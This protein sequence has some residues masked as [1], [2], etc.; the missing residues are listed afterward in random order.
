MG[1][2]NLGLGPALVSL[3]CVRRQSTAAR[4]LE[5]PAIARHHASPPGF[6]RFPIPK[7]T[8]LAQVLAAFEGCLRDHAA[9]LERRRGSGMIFLVILTY[10]YIYIHNI[11]IYIFIIIYIYTR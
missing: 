5:K 1:I 4:H 9:V 11:Y 3:E 6:C 7:R 8:R 2:F 10:T